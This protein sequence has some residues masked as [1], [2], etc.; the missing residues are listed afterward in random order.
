MKD[1]DHELDERTDSGFAPIKIDEDLRQK[2]L[3]HITTTE[4]SPTTYC[5]QILLEKPSPCPGVKHYE[6]VSYGRGYK[7]HEEAYESAMKFLAPK[8]IQGEPSR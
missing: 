8:L 4:V 1:H 2:G 6:Q 5:H 3:Y 7:S